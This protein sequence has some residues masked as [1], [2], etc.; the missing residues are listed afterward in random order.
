MGIV[1]FSFGGGGIFGK[2]IID[3]W[4]TFQGAGP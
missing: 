3:G 1:F 4:S 2:Y